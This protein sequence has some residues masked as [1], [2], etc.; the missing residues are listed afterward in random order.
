MN[1]KDV[2]VLLLHVLLLFACANFIKGRRRAAF[3]VGMPV[4]FVLFFLRFYVPV[5]FTGA[6]TLSQLTGRKRNWFSLLSGAALC[7]LVILWLGA[8]VLGTAVA[9][10]GSH[11]V[12][13]IFGF[14]RFILTPI[15]F[16][17]EQAYSFLDI[18]ALIHWAL[19]PVALV[20]IRVVYRQ[21]T[22]FS[23]FFLWYVGFF[24]TLYSFYGELQGPRH[25]V[26]VDFAWAL[27]QFLGL[28]AMLQR[29]F[30]Q[31]GTSLAFPTNPELKE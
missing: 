14:V 22:P 31:R 8:D 24:V 27:F 30:G 26:Q 29:V 17:T 11:F 15:P 10:A 5:L 4:V 3:L 19:F 20:G 21:N 16:N 6:L 2:L 7:G 9:S 18:P 13:P 12:N 28:A 25:R 1:G 23:R